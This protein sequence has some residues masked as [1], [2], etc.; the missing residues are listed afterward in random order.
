MHTLSSGKKFKQFQPL[1]W[2]A[3]T[4]DEEEGQTREEEEN[5]VKA[6]F[7]KQHLLVQ[8]QELNKY[9]PHVLYVYAYSGSV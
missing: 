3:F 4:P 8:R 9:N 5:P 2:T 7:W 1:K 6:Q